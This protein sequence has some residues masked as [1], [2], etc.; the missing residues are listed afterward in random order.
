MQPLTPVPNNP[1]VRAL[2]S[3][4][5]IAL[6]WYKAVHPLTAFCVAQL[7]DKRRTELIMSYGDA[8]IAHTRNN[9][10]CAFLESGADWLL[11][12]DDDSIVPFGNARWFNAHTGFNLPEPFA[13][14]NALDRL[15]SHGKTL[16]GALYFG[17]WKGANAVYGEGHI[18][19]EKQYSRTAPIDVCKP[20]RW[21]GTGCLLTHRSVFLDIEKTF[22]NLARGADGKLGQWYTSSEHMAMDLIRR[23]RE[24]LSQGPMTGEKAFK[25]M[26]MLTG[27]E[28][29][30]RS[31]SNLGMGEDVQLCTRAK[32]A[33]HQPY[34]DLG[35]VVGHVGN[36]IYG[37]KG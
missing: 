1:S 34:V 17:R 5:M 28:A 25:A 30:A 31:H 32:A 26:E 33:G 37:P 36:H 13:S 15:L 23:T 9:L 22:P 20:T 19:G 6:P 16:V 35:L 3:R 12:I 8:F 2:T 11:Q 4:V 24:M 18:D 14:L 27:G 10:A 29:Q 7:A 21:I